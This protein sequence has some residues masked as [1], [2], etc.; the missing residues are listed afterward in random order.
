MC[1]KTIQ[2]ILEKEELKAFLKLKKFLNQRTDA[3]VFRFV[4]KNHIR[5]FEERKTYLKELTELKEK[6]ETLFELYNNDVVLR[7][8]LETLL[9]D[10]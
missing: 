9:G 10:K 7:N 3:K 5:I 2:F 4:A 6:Y 8:K 1:K